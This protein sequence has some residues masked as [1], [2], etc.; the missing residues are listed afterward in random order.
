MQR[1]WH[2]NPRRNWVQN[3]ATLWNVVEAQEKQRNSQLARDVI[4]ALPRGLDDETYTRLVREFVNDNFVERG[5]VADFAVHDKDATDGGRNP[6]AHIMLSMRDVDKDGFSAKKNRSW[7]RKELVSQWRDAMERLCNR[8]LE[9]AGLAYRVSYSSYEK[10]GIDKIPGEHMGPGAWGLEQKKQKTDKGNRNR[11][12]RRDN[13]ANEIRKSWEPVLAPDNDNEPPKEPQEADKSSETRDSVSQPESEVAESPPALPDNLQG[14][15]RAQEDATS[16]AD[17]PAW[18]ARRD[19][20]VRSMASRSV[21]AT[22]AFVSR[23]ARYARDKAGE[24]MRDETSGG[25]PFTRYGDRYR[26]LR[27]V[28]R[29]LETESDKS[30]KQ[31]HER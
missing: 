17:P 30:D 22:V 28:S 9:E 1:F 19:A 24:L 4:V 23:M 27:Q 7:N 5:M 2:L 14:V 16:D 6:H 15:A 29:T 26:H 18:I 11:E 20:F 8:Y 12:V 31:D 21:Q 25:D 13:K 3:R 10:Q